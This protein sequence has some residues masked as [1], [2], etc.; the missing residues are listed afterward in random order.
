MK[1]FVLVFVLAAI[2]VAPLSLSEEQPKMSGEQAGEDEQ[3]IQIDDCG[4]S[5]SAN[6]CGSCAITCPV[7]KAA[8]CQ[9]GQE[10]KITGRCQ[11]PP[12]CSCE[13]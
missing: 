3:R 5:C 2:A 9:N 8:T 11:S 10:N 7:D 1:R 13:E 6:V 4:A 12:R